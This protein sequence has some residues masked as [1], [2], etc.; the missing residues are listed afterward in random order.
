MKMERC[1]TFLPNKSRSPAA[2]RL[3]CALVIGSPVQER[4]RTRPKDPLQCMK[5]N[6]YENPEPC[7]LDWIDPVHAAAEPDRC[8]GG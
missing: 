4:L 5:M 3:W 8:T 1:R 2:I 7:M 6:K